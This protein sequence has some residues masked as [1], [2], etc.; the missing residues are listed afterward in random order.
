MTVAQALTHT[1]FDT[2]RLQFTLRTA[3]ACCLSVLL[4]WL[5]GLE[6]PQWA[7]MTVWA[8]SLP[9]RDHMLE[10]SFFRVMGTVTGTLVGVLL[11]FVAGDQPL[12]L[13]IGMAIWLGLCA[14]I[15]N[16]QRSFVSYGTMLAGYSAIMVAM[17]GTPHP[18]H[19]LGLG[20]D[21]ML[22]ALLGVVA[23]LAVG[24]PF[25]RRQTREAATQQVQHMSGTILSHIA[26]RQRHQASH[27]D[28][29]VD[30]LL[31]EIATI[32]EQLD[33]LAAGSVQ[34]YRSIRPLRTLLSAQ[35]SALLWLKRGQNLVADET[36]ALALTHAADALE[37]RHAAEPAAQIMAKAITLP[38]CEPSLRAVLQGLQLALTGLSAAPRGRTQ[39]TTNTQRAV[40]HLDWV[41]ARQAMIRATLTF[42]FVGLIWV[43]TGW[44]GGPYMMI[45]TAVMMSIFSSFDSPAK[46]MGQVIF[47]G[48]FFGALVALACHW[49]VWPFATSETGLVLLMMPFILFGGLVA[50]NRRSMAY[51]YDF[52]MIMLILLQP[53]FPL[54]GT[55]GDS[56]VNS[57]AVVLAPLTAFVAFR[58]IYHSTPTT[59]IKTL[60]GMM[61]Q[62][63]QDIAGGQRLAAASHET[64]HARLY[65]RLITLVR[66]M[67]KS[68]E[69]SI[70]ALGGGVALQSLSTVAL[71]AQVLLHRPDITPGAARRLQILLKRMRS[72]RQQPERVIRALE[73]TATRLTRDAPVEARLLRETA[74][75]M[76]SNA[77]FFDQAARSAR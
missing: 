22:T 48:Q 31:C 8:A 68:G 67:N 49:L 23:A 37:H 47:W 53:A 30:A 6:H 29:T 65:H 72:L 40:I 16:L 44:R 32:D 54:T 74:H 59:R 75:V 33:L 58:L 14:G 56:L 13:V 34:S 62:D 45:G 24:W 46:I 4:A 35:V 50:G 12:W 1:G 71:R 57:I 38:S 60:I 64:R 7:G 20:A 36:L 51:S 25:A 19:M 17:L 5:L 27:P 61:V 26:Q 28:R 39:H 73:R 76:Q 42:L 9:I 43:F 41:G 77:A 52:N 10:K 69:Q 66:W 18:D 11:V 15:G 63:I 70:P 2:G 55:F 21:R 3:L